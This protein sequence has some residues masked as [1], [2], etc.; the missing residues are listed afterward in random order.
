MGK[1]KQKTSEKIREKLKLLPEKPGVYRMYNS[2]GKIIYIGKAIVLKNR[3]RSYFSGSSHD[4]KTEELV[5][6]I[7]DLDYIITET[8]YEAL[9]LEANLIKKHRPKYNIMLK[10]DR[11]YPFIAITMNE[12]FPRVFV[13][14][15][16]GKKGV[17]YFGPYTEVRA[18]R[19]I[20]RRFEWIFP[21]RNC[22]R[23]IPAHKIIHEKPCINFQL[24]KCPAPCVGYIT[25]EEY[26]KTIRSIFRFLQGRTDEIIDTF[27]SEMEGYAENLEFEKAA[28]TRDIIKNIESVTRNQHVHFADQSNRDV[29]GIYKDADRAAVSVLKILSG[30]LMNREIY[31]MDNVAGS[32]Y[33]EIMEAF[34][35]QYYTNKLDDLPYRILCQYEP[36]D[37]EAI[38]EMLKNK[39]IV[40][41]K[42]DNKQLIGLAKKNAFNH[43][44][45]LRLQHLKSKER[46]ILPVQELKEKLQL[47]KLPRRMICIDIS[48]IQGTDTV[49]SLV[50]FE[51]GKPKKKNY[52]HF[53]MKTVEGQDDFASMRETLTRYLAKID[54][55][56][57]P[58]LIVID[59]GKGQLSSAFSI[60]QEYKQDDIEMISLAKR[61]EEVFLPGQKT[62]ILLPRNSSALRLLIHIRDESH[63]FAVTFHRK[64][65][66]HRTLISDLD[67]VKGIGENKKFMLLKQF[68]SVANL[69]KASAEEIAVMPGIGIK[70]AESI[71]AQLKEMDN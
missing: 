37:F 39:V 58:D 32:E 13:T 60:L 54:N 17:K 44:E 45:E 43:V 27:K 21:T 38:N 57:K 14:R 30:K 29:I 49:S 61:I 9:V 69:R 19:R 33:P 56:V 55:Y 26:G 7:R 42:G 52:M 71:L 70:T 53:I 46:A 1:N 22:T 41:Q 3:V 50:F 64:R 8:E 5:S 4:P 2:K 65:R 25:Q 16:I 47:N 35:K 62:S 67:R 34:V 59:G 23:T 48:T 10:D 51:N 20:L 63:R 12:P 6:N 40:P 18:V 15:D 28:K 11:K 36:T 68:G 31:A 24:G 66:S